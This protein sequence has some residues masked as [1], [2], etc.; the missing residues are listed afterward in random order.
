MC[1]SASEE[2]ERGTSR[3]KGVLLFL[4]GW[5]EFTFFRISE[6]RTVNRAQPGSLVHLNKTVGTKPFV[7]CITLQETPD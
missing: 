5:I 4:S 1:P 7:S 6:F 2:L 3:G